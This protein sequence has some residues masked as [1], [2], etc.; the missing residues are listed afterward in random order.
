MDWNAYRFVST[1]RLGAS[2]GDVYRVLKDVDSYPLWWPEIRCV[3]RLD[4]R[5]AELA[6]RSLLP[7][8]LV[9]VT[10]ESRQDPAAGVLEAS[11]TGDLEGFSRWTV[12]SAGDGTRA[13][14]EE[15]VVARKELLRRLAYVARPAFQANHALMMLHGR[16]GLGVYLAGFQA[17]SRLD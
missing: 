4:D 7:Y 17:A 12:T 2:P 6:A 9:F 10:E 16:R 11:M 15:Q 8:D 3:R 13:V 14:F 1:W 5:R